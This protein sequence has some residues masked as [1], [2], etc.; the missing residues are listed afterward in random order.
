MQ[1][2]ASSPF[3][4]PRHARKGR[5]SGISGFADT[6]NFAT[7]QNLA[8]GDYDSAEAAGVAGDRNKVRRS[9]SFSFTKLIVSIR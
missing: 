5:L 6:F 7:K 3:P 9:I 1:P 4:S 2:P 8:G